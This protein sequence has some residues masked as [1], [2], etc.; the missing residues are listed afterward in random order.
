MAN[1]RDIVI[2]IFA[3][4]GFKP[5]EDM[6]NE[7]LIKETLRPFSMLD[8]GYS[9]F[10]E[11]DKD[12]FT[13]EAK[14][15]YSTIKRAFLNAYKSYHSGFTEEE[16]YLLSEYESAVSEK[17]NRHWEILR[18]SIQE[19][20]MDVDTELRNIISRIIMV[21][22]I[23]TYVCVFVDKSMMLNEGD[24]MVRM[25]GNKGRYIQHAK[26]KKNDYHKMVENLKVVFMNADKLAGIM[27]GR[28][29]G[30]AKLDI[31]NLDYSENFKN[32]MIA[33]FDAYLDIDIDIE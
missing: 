4:N 6:V 21:E 3:K 17:M 25:S 7:W 24:I 32:A 2:K 23:T 28:A 15:C 20:I 31:S 26:H 19:K 30:K 12:V 11:L 18:Y 9:E 14:Q 8:M 33:I 13:F 16:L 22:V 27:Y 29:H 10:C 1:L 5:K